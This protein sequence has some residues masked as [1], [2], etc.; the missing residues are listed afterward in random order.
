MARETDDPPTFRAVARR[1][2]ERALAQARVAI[3]A[4]VVSFDPAKRTIKAQPLIRRPGPVGGTIEEPALGD[5]PVLWPGSG[6]HRIRFP[7]R[8]GDS[9]LLVFL[10]LASDDWA[11]GMQQGT[12][13]NPPL[14]DPAEVRSHD[15]ADAVAIPISTFTAALQGELGSGAAPFAD[16]VVVENEN[17]Q[18]AL[19]DGGRVALGTRAPVP[20][21]LLDLVEQLITALQA[22]IVDIAGVPSLGATAQATVAAVKLQLQTIK[23]TL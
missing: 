20:I 15:F 7:L 9:V 6:R 1:V 23:G 8:A 18:I 5:I 16:R 19:I 22:S 17:A 12:A 3:P 10:D 11:L 4:K 13:T 14:V 21:E 2:I